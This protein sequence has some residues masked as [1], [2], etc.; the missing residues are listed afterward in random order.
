MQA[1]SLMD[2]ES[3][4]YSEVRSKK[5][6]FIIDRYYYYGSSFKLSQAFKDNFSLQCR[7]NMLPIHYTDVLPVGN[8]RVPTTYRFMVT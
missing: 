8:Q 4:P 1:V 6:R 7:S 2:F 3:V 5:L